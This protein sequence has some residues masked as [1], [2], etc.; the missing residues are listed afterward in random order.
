MKRSMVASVVLLAALSLQAHGQE[1][2]IAGTVHDLEGKPISGAVVYAYERARVIGRFVR[3]ETRS[4]LDG[5]FLIKGVLPGSYQ[6]HAYKEVD[7]YPDTFFAFFNT[8]KNGW[9]DVEVSPSRVSNV[10]LE[11]GPKGAW[12]SVSI[13]DEAG[14]EVSGNLGFQK[15]NENNP[16]Y[17]ESVDPGS[18]VLVPPIAFRIIVTAPH[19]AKWQSEVL[20]PKSGETI[21][22]YVRLKRSSL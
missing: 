7:G 3:L 9:K 16:S 19:F 14:N 22:V 13:R 11:L 12:L 4:K 6:V 10:A 8:N 17:S 1:S 18:R 15:L 20:K 5:Q 21:P 2:A